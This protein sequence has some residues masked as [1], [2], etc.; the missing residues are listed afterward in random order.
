[1]WDRAR[2]TKHCV[3]LGRRAARWLAWGSL[4]GVAACSAGLGESDAP[5]TASP[6][7]P[8]KR[9]PVCP[10]LDARSLGQTG[11]A[12][13]ADS[14]ACGTIVASS[15]FSHDCLADAKCP[16]AP[17]LLPA[18]SEDLDAIGV[19][20]LASHASAYLGK[21]V[22]LRGELWAF[23]GQTMAYCDG[24][25]NE[26]SGALVLGPESTKAVLKPFIALVDPGAPSAFYCGGDDSLACCGFDAGGLNSPTLVAVSG[27]FVQRRRGEVLI[28]PVAETRAFGVVMEPKL[29]RLRPQPDQPLHECTSAEQR[30]LVDRCAAGD[31]EPFDVGAL[32]CAC[33]AGRLSCTPERSACFRAGNWY[34]E[35]G[36]PVP[37]SAS[38]RNLACRSGQWEVRGEECF[39]RLGIVRFLP[40]ETQIRPSESEA[41]DWLARRAGLP[42]HVL[43]SHPDP[44]EG[45]RGRL[46][47]QRR[48]SAVRSALRLAQPKLEPSVEVSSVSRND[49]R[50]R[51]ALRGTRLVD[52][53]PAER[54]TWECKPLSARGGTDPETH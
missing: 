17:A 51:L 27:T 24:C 40:G 41:L 36:E 32:R 15:E 19:D 25:C 46:L 9:V 10:T 34:P 13:A 23:V 52:A 48:A 21:A 49:P 42:G 26:A 31:R 7:A 22:V 16:R 38:C 44:S 14:A 29:C 54:T 35:G 1:M 47:A 18:C 50:Q 28:E 43:R 3:G 53:R 4:S 30:A 33:H 8:L 6:E 20:E 11:W 2:A 12:S 45:A 5:S 39:A 37:I